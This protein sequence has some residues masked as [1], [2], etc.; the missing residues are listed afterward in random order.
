MTADRS[1]FQ[2]LYRFQLL[3]L[4]VIGSLLLNANALASTS[5]SKSPNDPNSYRYLE[6]DNGLRVI[7]ASD[8]EADKAA[9]SMN[10]SVGS[11]ND[12]ADREG[13]A[14]RKSTRLNSSH[15]RISYAV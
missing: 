15:V 6:L 10:V 11:G 12:P 13:L 8:P 9:A 4:L 2:R 14:D 3:L 1:L 5:P 7:L